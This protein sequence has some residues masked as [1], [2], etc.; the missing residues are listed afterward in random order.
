M[1]KDV[2]VKIA[3]E[4]KPED[5]IRFCSTEKEVYKNVCD[6]EIFW[7]LKLEK[8]YPEIYKNLKKPVLQAKKEYI[9]EFTLS[10]NIEKTINKILDLYILTSSDRKKYSKNMYEVIYERYKEFE[11]QDLNVSHEDFEFYLNEIIPR[12]VI[13]EFDVDIAN[14]IK[15]YRIKPHLRTNLQK[16]VT[17]VLKELFFNLLN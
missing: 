13:D 9:K 1:N 4:L 7:R 11:S 5:L 12:Y 6:S 17:R 8:D 16:Y 2:I 10:K 3:L 15:G 14:K